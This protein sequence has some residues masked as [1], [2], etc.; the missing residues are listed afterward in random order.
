MRFS[1]GMDANTKV[2]TPAVTVP[3]LVM[4]IAFG[5]LWRAPRA[6]FEAPAA[7]NRLAPVPKRV[8]PLTVVV[9]TLKPDDVK[10]E[11][12]ATVIE[13]CVMALPA[14][15]CAAAV[16]V[17]AL[18]NDPPAVIRTATPLLKALFKWRLR[19]VALAPAV[20]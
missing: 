13:S 19:A 10:V 5:E 3:Q 7:V 17:P 20:T 18:D 16:T 15:F 2:L 4:V 12:A 8:R 11:A 1:C 9:W 14:I 6:K